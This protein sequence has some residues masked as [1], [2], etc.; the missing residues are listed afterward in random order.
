MFGTHLDDLHVLE[1][2]TSHGGQWSRRKEMYSV[3][4]QRSKQPQVLFKLIHFIYTSKMAQSLLTKSVDNVEPTATIRPAFSGVRKRTF[5]QEFLNY[6]TT[7]KAAHSYS[8]DPLQLQFALKKTRDLLSEDRDSEKLLKAGT[9][10]WEKWNRKEW[11][12][13]DDVLSDLSISF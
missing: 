12:S 9:K 5:T 3:Y 7:G 11:V 6:F 13:T 1:T 8:S 10:S 4:V 2:M